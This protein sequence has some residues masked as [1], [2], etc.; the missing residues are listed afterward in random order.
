M[1]IQV[2]KYQLFGELNVC[3][4]K[5]SF[6]KERYIIYLFMTEKGQLCLQSIIVGELFISSVQISKINKINK[7]N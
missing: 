7:S 4:H 5:L 1:L 3:C 2:L 6:D